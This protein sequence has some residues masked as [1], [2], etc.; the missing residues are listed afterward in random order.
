MTHDRRGED[1]FALTQEF[2]AMMLGVR[3]ASVSI[4]A[5]ALKAAGLVDYHRG[6]VQVIDRAGLEAAA[7]ECYR[8]TRDEYD[9]VLGGPLHGTES[10]VSR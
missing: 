7:C 8:V 1:A 2:L 6:G 4:A 10:V 3:R 9:R 5:S